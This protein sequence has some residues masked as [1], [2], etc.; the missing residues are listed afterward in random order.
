MRNKSNRTLGENK[1]NQSQSP[2]AQGWG[3]K[4][5]NDV[6][7][8]LGCMKNPTAC[9]D[10]HGTA[11]N[12]DMH[13][14]SAKKILTVTRCVLISSGYDFTRHSLPARSRSG[15][16]RLWRRRVMCL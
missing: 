3:L 8:P 4:V 11:S 6:N 2:P 12:Y 10:E 7:Y 13:P 5:D 14:T 16:G 15:E 1:P 9:C